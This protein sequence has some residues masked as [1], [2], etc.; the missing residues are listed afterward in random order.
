MSVNLET[1]TTLTRDNTTNVTGGPVVWPDNKIGQ[2]QVYTGELY[3]GMDLC[4]DPLGIPKGHTCVLKP[5]THPCMDQQVY[6]TCGSVNTDII[7]NDKMVMHCQVCGGK[8]SVLGDVDPRAGHIEVQISW[9]PNSFDGLIN[10][11]GVGILGYAVYA[12]NDCG[13][14]MGP[15]LATVTSLSVAQ[16]T[17]TCCEPE[18]YGATIVYQLALGQTSQSFMVVPLTS[19]GALD[20]GWTT[21]PVV[22]STQVVNRASVSSA[23]LLDSTSE[24][25]ETMKRPLDAATEIAKI[26][27]SMTMNV[28]YQKLTYDDKND[29]TG[30]VQ[31]IVVESAG[32]PQ[33]VV[34][35]M[36]SPGSVKVKAVIHTPNQDSADS[37]AK[38]IQ[39]N[40]DRIAAKV[41]EAADSTPGVKAAAIG[42]L[43]ITIIEVKS[44]DQAWEGSVTAVSP[45]ESSE[46]YRS[47]PGSQPAAPGEAKVATADEAQDG[48]PDED[49]QIGLIVGLGVG[50]PASFAFLSAFFLYRKGVF[51]KN[52][53]QLYAI[54]D[55]NTGSSKQP[56][57]STG[58][59]PQMAETQGY[60]TRVT[61]T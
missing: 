39:T 1:K 50:I 51:S 19:I 42:K 3:A 5:I 30:K 38:S 58:P 40:L 56:D 41:L 25:S 49:S 31:D 10:E 47:Q 24:S 17:E 20:A 52:M 36:L 27:L 11:L 44:E 60:E 59:P 9:G 4:G 14:K 45:E 37:V 12:V 22:D 61:A 6:F 43:A 54:S 23:L 26:A 57:V 48:T 55:D 21:A 28:D 33:A 18:M 29:F 46:K 7:E 34:V 32:D 2:P 16:G 8:T 15:V 35:V 13:E 53:G